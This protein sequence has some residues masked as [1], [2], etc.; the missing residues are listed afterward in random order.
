MLE[1]NQ[2]TER[3]LSRLTHRLKSWRVRFFVRALHLGPN[4]SVL[5]LGSEDG[6]YLAR[7]YPYPQNL[8]L[9]DLAEAPMKRG[10]ERYG[11]RGYIV[12]PEEG[13][14]P[15]RDRQYDAV[16]CNSVIEH[17]TVPRKELASI[18]HKEFCRRADEHQRRF[19]AEIRRIALRYFVQTPYV[20]FPVEAH[21]WL[22][23]V[24]YLPHTT[25][26][27]LSRR[28]RRLWVKQW[29]PDFHLY[30][31]RRFQGHFPDATAFHVERVLG[32]PKSLMAIRTA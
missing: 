19:A 22:P 31:F 20:H 25:R 10:V 5:D 30:D 27:W 2:Y 14:L 9:A 26:W 8:V 3:Q 6:S 11:L 24:Q 1:W 17:V 12:L 18:Q 32:L 7:Y 16:W 4:H 23:L 29:T 15:I 21:S 28:L 13:L